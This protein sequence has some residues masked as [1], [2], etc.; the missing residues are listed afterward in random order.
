MKANHRKLTV[1]KA[2]IDLYE[3]REMR[4]SS[5]EALSLIT[6]GVIEVMPTK[7]IL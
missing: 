4:V 3:A 2:R 1:S 7:V 5:N 6:F